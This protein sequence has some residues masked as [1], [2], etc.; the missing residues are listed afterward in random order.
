ILSEIKQDSSTTTARAILK[1]L[2]PRPSPNFKLSDIDSTTAAYIVECSKNCHPDDPSTTKQIRRS[3]SNYF[4]SIKHRKKRKAI[5]LNA[6][7]RNQ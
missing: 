3:M 1:Y 2:Y 5:I 6:G 7:G 4:A